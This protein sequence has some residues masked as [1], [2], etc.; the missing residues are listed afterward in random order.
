MAQKLANKYKLKSALK[1][2]SLAITMFTGI[3]IYQGNEKFYNNIVM[4]IIRILDPESAH[5]LAITILKYR[6]LHKQTAPDPP[7][8]AA[9]L[10]GIEFQNPLGMAAGFDKQGE[11]YEGLLDQGFSFVEIGNV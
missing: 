5:N 7:S 11:A 8:L 9:N 3:N 10:W 6:L 4:P 2:T 1:I